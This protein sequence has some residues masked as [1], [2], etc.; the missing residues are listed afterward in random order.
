MSEP[1]PNLPRTGVRGFGISPAFPV[2]SD[3]RTPRTPSKSKRGNGE[4]KAGYPATPLSLRPGS[5]RFGGFAP[6]EAHK[7][8]TVTP[9]PLNDRKGVRSSEAGGSPIPPHD[10]RR[11]IS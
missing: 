9:N 7:D 4:G 5:G 10:Q 1:P 2:L 3:L 11:N 6:L 8:Q